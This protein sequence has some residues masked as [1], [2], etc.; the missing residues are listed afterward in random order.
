[1]QVIVES[2]FVVIMQ[3]CSLQSPA[4][5][6]IIDTYND[7]R[8]QECHKMSATSK[9]WSESK[10]ETEMLGS[11]RPCDQEMDLQYYEELPKY[12][13]SI[14]QKK[15]TIIQ[16]NQYRSSRINSHLLYNLSK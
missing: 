10:H 3:H 15:P 9:E 11:W 2:F 12:E 13:Y 8:E 6:A 5:Y 7:T 16:Y 4:S 1:M 14:I